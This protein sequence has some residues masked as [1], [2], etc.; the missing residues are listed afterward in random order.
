MKIKDCKLEMEV[1]GKNMFNLTYFIVKINKTT[2]WAEH[3][4]GNTRVYGGKQIPENYLYK[5]VRPSTL[6]LIKEK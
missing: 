2:I 6:T 5:N 4:T 1:T 3:R